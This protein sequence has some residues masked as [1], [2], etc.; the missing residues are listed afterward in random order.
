MGLGASKFEEIYRYSGG[1]NEKKPEA[2][3]II[4]QP[5]SLPG[6]EKGH[7]D[8]NKPKNKYSRLSVHK[9]QPEKLILEK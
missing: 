3:A 5:V 7:K 9:I 4:R 6:K 1:R 8:I 2:S